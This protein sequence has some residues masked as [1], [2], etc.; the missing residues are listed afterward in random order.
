MSSPQKSPGG[1]RRPSG[2]GASLWGSLGAK[3]KA[4]P[5]SELAHI[6]MRKPAA[7]PNVEVP[8]TPSANNTGAAAPEKR[9]NLTKDLKSSASLPALPAKPAVKAAQASSP[10][11]AKPKRVAFVE[12][13]QADSSTPPPPPPPPPPPKPAARFVLTPN[14]AAEAAEAAAAL[15]QEVE[16]AAASAAK[17]DKPASGEAAASEQ[18]D[19]PEKPLIALPTPA[20]D[21][22]TGHKK[23]TR[24]A[25]LDSKA[26]EYTSLSDKPPPKAQAPPPPPPKPSSSSTSTKAQ[27]SPPPAPPPPPIEVSERREKPSKGIGLGLAKD[28]ATGH[29]AVNAAERA[30]SRRGADATTRAK[31]AGGTQRESKALQT[32]A[33]MTPAK[34]V[35]E[36]AR[37]RPERS[38]R[39]ARGWRS[40]GT[41]CCAR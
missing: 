28:G 31:T 41:I 38:K 18:P 30:G 10:A 12:G 34:E 20:F 32:P 23:S 40:S 29:L 33:A 1:L 3:S 7:L 15:A 6:K 21:P 17:V 9:V 13:G 4:S 11:A 25:V 16:Q 27:T 39:P 24:H 36:G 14:K 26:R 37:R 2:L 5:P 19:K 8:M 22:R 35:V